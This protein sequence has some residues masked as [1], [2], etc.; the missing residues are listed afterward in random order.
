MAYK[1]APEVLTCSGSEDI[2]I[3]LFWVFFL[4][5]KGEGL[6]PSPGGTAILEEA[7]DIAALDENVIF[8][9][10]YKLYKTFL[11]NSQA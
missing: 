8:H 1:R 6:P 2:G 10:A 3:I 7:Y 4:K 5:L 9:Y 11:P